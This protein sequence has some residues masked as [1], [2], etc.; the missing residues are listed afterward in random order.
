VSQNNEPVPAAFL[1][2]VGPTPGP[3]PGYVGIRGIIG[4]TPETAR[5]VVVMIEV[6]DIPAL[7]HD[8]LGRVPK[9]EES[10]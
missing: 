8:L 4:N 1:D 2:V 6:S 10:A 7:V 3:Q 5:R 9:K